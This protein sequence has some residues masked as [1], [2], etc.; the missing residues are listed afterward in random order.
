MK[1]DVVCVG[2]A[3]AQARCHQHEESVPPM[4]IPD[5]FREIRQ[6]RLALARAFAG[7]L[8]RPVHLRLTQPHCR[9]PLLGENPLRRHRS[10]YLARRE[11]HQH[12]RLRPP[13]IAVL[14]GY[15]QN[16]HADLADHLMPRPDQRPPP[17]RTTRSPAPGN[18]PGR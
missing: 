2:M 8:Q 1:L 17:W 18:T 6:R 4:N 11:A 7:Q 5:F 9:H 12:R 15:D 3:I 16:I 14:T 10:R 13:P